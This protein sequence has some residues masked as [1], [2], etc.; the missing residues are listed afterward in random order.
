MALREFTDRAGRRWR[1]W[2]VTADAIHPATRTEDYM[3]DYLEGWLAFE[4]LDGLAKCRLTPIPARWIAASVEQLEQWLHQAETVRGDRSSGA[5]GRASAEVASNPSLATHPAATGTRGPVR[6]FRF[7]GGRYWTVTEYHP[8]VASH[9]DG[10]AGGHP[11]RVLRFMSGA[12]AL[13]LTPWPADWLS[14]SDAELA[15]LLT[16]SFP[17]HSDP[18]ESTA[19]RRRSGDV[20][21]R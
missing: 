11:K 20:E 1:A 18:S 6:T 3:R 5:Y 17:R 14:L 8:T 9:D 19:Q 4:S 13:D 10:A 21:K 2:D 15:E 12:R 16:T 7:P